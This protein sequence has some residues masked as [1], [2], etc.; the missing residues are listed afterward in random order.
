[1]GENSGHNNL[2]P[3][4]KGEVRNPNGRGK[5]VRNRATI[6]K[7]MLEQAA[8]ASINKKQAQAL[9]PT[10]DGEQPIVLEQKTIADQVVT[11]LLISALSG[12][13]AAARE[14]LD[15]GYGKLTDNVNNTHSF[16]KMGTIEAA[17]DGKIIDGTAKSVPLSFDV[18]SPPLHEALEEE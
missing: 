18:G 1:M 4:V 7:E 14:L 5:G 3:P 11:A 8:L 13:V 12:D 17:V 10:A 15:S 16:T 2:I 9:A 6:F